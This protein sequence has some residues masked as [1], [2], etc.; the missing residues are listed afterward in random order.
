LL[1]RVRRRRKQQPDCDGE[2]E[3]HQLILMAVTVLSFELPLELKSIFPVV[4]LSSLQL[5]RSNGNCKRSAA[6]PA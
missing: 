1:L 3:F 2:N 4:A 5:M 6:P